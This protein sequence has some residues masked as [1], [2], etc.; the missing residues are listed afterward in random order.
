MT[1]QIL[2]P[3]VERA[4]A[5]YW[6]WR[7][8]DLPEF[9][10]FV[11][12]H[13]QDDKLDDLSLAAHEARYRQCQA[14]LEEAKALQSSLTKHVD[15]INVKALIAE[16]ETYVEGFQYKGYLLPLCTMEGIHVDF[17]RLISWMR[18]E[19]VEDYENLLSRY[20]FLPKQL[21][22]IEELM[23]QGVSEGIV[24]HAISMKG[25]AKSLGSFVVENE[26]DSQLWK[27]FLHIPNAI[28]DEDKRKELQEKAGRIIKEEI[29]P[30]F[31]K[32]QYFV[33][34]NYKT[35]PNIA[36]T[37]LPDGE[38]RYKQLLKFHTLKDYSAKEIH[39]IGLSEVDRIE[40][41]MEEMAPEVLNDQ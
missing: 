18:L 19:K 7:I 28:A 1:S 23:S 11:G 22:Q 5:G 38:N 4:A 30:A 26:E 17:Q 14:F 37:T 24:H 3:C 2:S 34:N 25:V 39:Q 41:K 40:G 21:T 6:Q 29:S 27:P 15:V 31:K 8:N 33:S 35:R 32:L 12:I 36:V 10:S 13:N 9:S 20:K 16:L